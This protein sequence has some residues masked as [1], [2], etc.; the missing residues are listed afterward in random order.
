MRGVCWAIVFVTC[1]SAWHH[2]VNPQKKKNDTVGRVY[3]Q[4]CF[5]FV[6]S[7]SNQTRCFSQKEESIYSTLLWGKHPLG[8]HNISLCI[9]QLDESATTGMFSML[10]QTDSRKN[11]WM[12]KDGVSC[13][14]C[15]KPVAQFHRVSFLSLEVFSTIGLQQTNL[16]LESQTWL[17]M[18]D[19]FWG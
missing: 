10:L 6:L 4:S 9:L 12:S 5:I 3:C 13:S 14:M 16:D 18:A 7:E 15:S 2:N 1:A 11:Q 17:Y 19:S 8:W